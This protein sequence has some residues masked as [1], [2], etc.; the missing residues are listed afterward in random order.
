MTQELS[1]IT[2]ATTLVV[3]SQES[4]IQAATVLGK[5]KD[6]I[7]K[8]KEEEENLSEQL[9]ELELTKQYNSKR[10]FRLKAE[11]A[12]KF[13]SEQVNKYQT[14]EA[15]RASEEAARI[16]A[17]V[18]RGTMKLDTAVR[19]M[20]EIEQPLTKLETADTKVTFKT[21]PKLDIIDTDLIP[22]EYM[23]VNEVAV[24][25]A[26]KTGKTIPGAQ[27]IQVQSITNR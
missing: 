27:I 3:N 21:I 7:K 22:R 19:K 11:K 2:K 15:K 25:A 9:A 16:A 5:V 6:L 4:M 10:E 26:L 8:T 20:G 14:L 1:L 17:R 24:F 13:I 12:S 23:I 18:E